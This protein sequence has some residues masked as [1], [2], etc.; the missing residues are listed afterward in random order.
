MYS[1]ILRI[2]LIG[3]T[4]L[5]MRHFLSHL[6]GWTEDH[7]ATINNTDMVNNVALVA[8]EKLVSRPPCVCLACRPGLVDR[9]A[10]VGHTA[11]QVAPRVCRAQH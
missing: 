4:L 11:R 5:C 1:A 2:V 10:P 6:P 9:P 3:G 8:G 7:F